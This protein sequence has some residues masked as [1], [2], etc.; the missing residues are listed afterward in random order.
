MNMLK[1]DKTETGVLGKI[2]AGHGGIL[3]V[4]ILFIL[5]FSTTTATFLKGPNIILIIRQAS[6]SC[7][8][9]FGITLVLIA[10]S[11]DLSIGS[12]GALAGIVA[13][14]L[15]TE[16]EAP[17]SAAVLAAVMTGLLA[18]MV[19]GLI[20]TRIGIPAF[21]TTLGVSYICRGAAYLLS[22]GQSITLMIGKF[23][24]LGTGSFLGIPLLIWYMLV[25]MLVLGVFMTRTR[26]GRYIYAR[27]SNP[28]A[29]R[30]A[31]IRA[32]GLLVLVHC[33]ACSLAGFA[34]AINAA[35]VFGATPGA[36]EGGE[37]D[38]IC[39]A[40]LGGTSMAGG[41]GSLVGTLLGALIV[42]V[43]SNG[44]NHAGLN[45]YWQQVVKGLLVIIAVGIDIIKRKIENQRLMAKA[46]EASEA[47]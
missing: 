28:T 46:L 37:I 7:L 9:A 38:A 11:I 25:V 30:F 21:I 47:Q 19:S 43:M 32:D 15:L 27:G 31:G 26:T 35:R 34:G 29:A 2:F 20:I 18:G 33:I 36:G 45:A 39:A 8:T 14:L 23:N 12:V 42:C 6:T 3:A 24:D 13:G 4:L 41:S 22:G 10:G 17:V 5:L 40:V 44:L 16:A 1:K